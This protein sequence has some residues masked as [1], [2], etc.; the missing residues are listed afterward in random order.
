MPHAEHTAGRP[1]R[2]RAAEPGDAEGIAEVFACPSVIAGT[3]ALP[4]RSV[5]DLR[6]RMG[7]QPGSEWH[8]LVAEWEGRVV[9]SLLLRVEAQPR[10]RH[11]ASF[12]M[13]VHDAYRRRGVGSALIAAMLDLADNWLGLSRIELE[14]YTDN[15]PAIALYRKFGFEVEGTARQFA[16]QDGILVDAY[17]MARLR[18]PVS[19]AER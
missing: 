16:L 8:R 12:G 4:Y 18:E 11:A 15:A 1:I 14:V 7:E 17:R 5:E 2:V 10:R 6:R 3:F 13:G 9:G 19:S